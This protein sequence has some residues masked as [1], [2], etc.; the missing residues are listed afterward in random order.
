MPGGPEQFRADH[1]GLTL[2]IP[3]QTHS[4]NI[5]VVT[6]EN[7][8]D[9]FPDTD[10]LITELRGVAIGV[11][12][13][14]CMPCL[15]SDERAGRIAAVHAG[16]RGT[17][18]RILRL[19]IEKMLE[20]GSRPSDLHIYLGPAICSPCYEIGEDVARPFRSTEMAPAITSSLVPRPSH[21][22]ASP[23]SPVPRPSH[24]SLAEANKLQIADLIPAEN[25]ELD[26]R[27]TCHT[28]T[29][30]GFLFPSYR[31]SGTT[32]RLLS[33]LCIP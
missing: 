12:T 4:C 15:I 23:S 31:R 1:P 28:R 8:H 24:L 11:R 9:P 3:Q 27:C 22:F 13:A 29:G 20:M 33:A 2:V 10:A 5:A 18:G 14:D 30:S 17:L 21:L 32:R 26:S 19:T 16:R 6:A 7:L 25:I